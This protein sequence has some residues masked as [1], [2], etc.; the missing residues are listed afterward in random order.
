MN[1]IPTVN[2]VVALEHRA[3]EWWQ[4]PRSRRQMLRTRSG[5]LYDVTR[6]YTGWRLTEAR[7]EARRI[8]DN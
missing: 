7:T 1:V 3:V 5:R 6:T 8:G 2:L 4:D